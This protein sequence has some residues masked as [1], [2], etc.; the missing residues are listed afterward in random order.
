MPPVVPQSPVRLSEA[1][2]R[3]REL[4]R[5]AFLGVLIISGLLL[6]SLLL[7]KAHNAVRSGQPEAQPTLSDP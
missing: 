4:I 5:A 6:V 3:R 7:Y 1:E 2:Q